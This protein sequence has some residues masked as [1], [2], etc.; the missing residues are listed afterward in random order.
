[1]TRNTVTALMILLTSFV[2]SLSAE[3]PVFTHGPLITAE[4]LDDLRARG[5]IEG[6]TFIV[7]QNGA[8]DR[9]VDEL[10]GFVEPSD[11][12]E[13]S[14]F[15][16]CTP[17]RDLPD[18]FDWRDSG[19][20]TPIK[21]QSSCGSC[22]AFSTVGALECNIKV[23]DGIT[24]DLSEQWLVS[25]NTDGWDC[26]GG[27][28]AHDYHQWKTDPCGDTGAVLEAE[29]PYTAT[30]APC[31]CP[32]PH[33]YFI[34]SWAFVGSQGGIPSTDAIKQ[35]IYDHGPISIAV[36]VTSAF[37]YYTG[38]IFNEHA[39]GS[40]NHAVVLVGWDDNQGSSGVWMLR[41]SWGSG[42]GESGYMRIEYECNNVGYAACYVNYPG[43]TL[44]FDYPNGRPDML[45]PDEPT[46][47]QVQVA[48]DM[49]TPIPGTGTLHY[50]LNGAEFTTVPMTQ[51]VPNL[52]DATLPAGSCFDRY[53]WYV[54]VQEANGG[55]KTDPP[56]AEDHTYT[57]VVATEMITV[58]DDDFETNQGWT[59]SAG[60]TTGNWERADPEQVYYPDIGDD[61]QPG[62]D[63]SPDGSLC[64]V[65]G[66]LAGSGVGSHDVDGGPTYL[67]SPS[68]DLTDMAHP[69]VR[70][71]RWYHISTRWDDELTVEVSNNNGSSWVIVEIVDMRETWTEVTWLVEDYVT[72][73]DQ[74]RVR[75]T[76]IDTD[77]GSLIEALIDDFEIRHFEC[78]GGQLSAPAVSITENGTMVTLTWAPIT[79]A[80][81][82]RVYSSGDAHHDFTEDVGGTFLGE[83][84][85]T[86]IDE[87]PRYYYVTAYAP[88]SESDPS[89]TTG[90]LFMDTDIP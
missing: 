31:N 86:I 88:S 1:M 50:A 85:S 29:F 5:E 73:T 72:P 74:I 63:H 3:D 76:A 33:K 19:G 51:T 45:V 9:T 38:G 25:C 75:F 46:T 18:A 67:T 47:F 40:V 7:D 36:Y 23:K 17:M 54:S 37:H 61:T 41:N 15:D 77:P 8:T 22:W 12:R 39:S 20:C 89:N 21:N 65:T 83:S 6:W 26:G 69:N 71:W 2:S 64:Y 30:D 57:A 48:A 10:C 14:R 44:T 87:N 82:Y 80:T 68:F 42:W 11:W 59:V 84:W 43:L 55:W 35:A 4:V 81:G 56:D 58:F 13:T 66:P 28:Y 60:A 79:G 27:W 62:N 49:G 78:N 34:D 52:Y 70:Y 32:Y 24:E 90:L 53:D 16:P